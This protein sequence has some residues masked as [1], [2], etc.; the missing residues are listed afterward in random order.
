MPIINPDRLVDYFVV[1]GLDDSGNPAIVDRFPPEDREDSALP[2]ALP[3]FCMPLSDSKQAVAPSPRSSRSSSCSAAQPLRGAGGESDE[4]R[5]ALQPLTASSPRFFTFVLTKV[6]G[7]KSYGAALAVHEQQ[8]HPKV[9]CFVSHW[10]FFTL[11]KAM[12]GSLW[13]HAQ[14]RNVLRLGHGAGL[15]GVQRHRFV[16]AAQGQSNPLRVID[17]RHA[18][19]HRGV[20]R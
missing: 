7:R 13:Q 9:L 8:R 12:L 3:A 19:G 18:P 14:L 1:V 4:R 2:K 17:G 20:R 16:S 5:P 6:D 11:Y 15:L 10:P